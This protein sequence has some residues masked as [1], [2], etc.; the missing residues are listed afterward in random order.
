[1]T[2]EALLGVNFLMDGTLL[3]FCGRLLGRSPRLWRVAAAAALGA[4]WAL[5]S[6]H[7]RLI[8]LG[9]L[10][11]RLLL[12]EVMILCAFGRTGWRAMLRLSLTLWAL[13]LGAGGAALAAQILGAGVYAGNLCAICSLLLCG[14]RGPARLDPRASFRVVFSYGGQ[15]WTGLLDTGNCLREPRTGA[16]VIVAGPEL[17]RLLPGNRER[18]LVVGTAAGT[19]Q[20][21]AYAMERIAFSYAGRSY[22]VPL[23][24]G[25]PSSGALED[26]LDAVLPPWPFMEGSYDTGMDQATA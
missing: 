19:S 24:W 9:S 14:C 11:A 25:V 2:M 3:V 22:T 21:T 23:S 6:T 26:G 13:L 7:P 15:R 8:F 16:F 12:P 20:K 18:T 10:P 4:L 17:A 1:M 5:F